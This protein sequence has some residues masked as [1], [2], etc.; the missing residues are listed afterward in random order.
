MV[1]ADSLALFSDP[2]CDSV[3][4]HGRVSLGRWTTSVDRQALESVPR[5]EHL[6]FISHSTA[7][8]E[9]HRHQEPAGQWDQV[10]THW[11]K[12]VRGLLDRVQ[13]VHVDLGEC[14]LDEY[15]RMV[16]AYLDHIRDAALA[17]II[18]RYRTDL[19]EGA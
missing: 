3:H 14:Y 18:E 4:H 6:G 17:R 1:V 13:L 11:V 19:A 9:G 16:S 7:S 15:Y 10:P 8:G 12:E 5:A 2:P